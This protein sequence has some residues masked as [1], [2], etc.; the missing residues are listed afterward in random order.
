MPGGTSGAFKRAGII[1]SAIDAG[2][3]LVV[4]RHEIHALDPYVRAQETGANK[5]NEE[6]AEAGNVPLCAAACCGK[7]GC[8]HRNLLTVLTTMSASWESGKLVRE[9]FL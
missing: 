8:F 2:V 1:P 4:Q 5:E 6:A 7:V 9:G 3:V